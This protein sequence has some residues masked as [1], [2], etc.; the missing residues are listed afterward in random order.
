MATATSQTTRAFEPSNT[1]I[2]GTG[3]KLVVE[4][5][6]TFFLVF[7]VGATVRTGTALAPLAIG[8]ALMV[9]VYMGGHIS[10]GHYNP[11]VSFGLFLRRKI[12]PGQMVAYWAAQLFAAVLAFWLGFALPGMSAG[13][14]PHPAGAIWQSISV[15]A[16][17]TTALVLVVLNVAATSATSGNSYYGLAIGFT[18]AVGAFVAGPISGGGFNPAAGFGATSVS[19]FAVGRDS[20]RIW[21]YLL[22]TFLTAA[23][24]AG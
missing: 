22:V 19:A 8:A 24:H 20:G 4:L 18:I 9:M 2:F 10:G 6:G 3:R 1:V 16:F 14:H 15:E 23:N 5:I 12:G 17:F 13:I 7:T 11:A 21:I